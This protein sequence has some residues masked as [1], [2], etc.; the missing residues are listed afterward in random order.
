L[1]QLR[2][3]AGPD[4]VTDAAANTHFQL[5]LR[6][7]SQLSVMLIG[8]AVALAVLQAGQVI[9]APV[10]LAITVGLMFGPVADIMEKRGVPS[11]LSAAVI[12][13]L[14]LAIIIAGGALFAAP[15]AEWVARIPV[16]WER[17]RAELA[18]LR[19]PLAAFGALQEQ[20][21]DLTGGD[22]AMAVTVE[23][24][25]A[26]TELA[27]L[28]PAILAQVLIFLASLYFFMATRESIRIS[29]LSLCVSR[30]MRW[31]T[32][33][34]FRDVE[35]KVSKYLLTI[36]T[37]NIG[38]GVVVTA[39]MWAIG[40]P[41]PLLWGALAAV[42]NYIPFV[43]QAVMALI[44]F[45][46]GL[47]TQTGISGAMLP[48]VLYW[49]VNFTEG[50]FV[51]PNLLG[52]T[53]T[54]NPFLIFLSLTF[55]IWSWGPIGGL[56]AVPSLLILYSLA[57]HILPVGPLAHRQDRRPLRRGSQQPPATGSEPPVGA[58]P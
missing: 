29:T 57:T 34:V 22:G 7:A 39:I 58:V 12:V 40:L 9:L 5:L 55:W 32:A 31:R 17:F 1:R 18:N 52:R 48:V 14:L 27:L 21:K 41:S 28:A 49:A 42:L 11:T 36:S 19:E 8:L 20:V 33:H 26:V 6:N 23:D 24:G 38:V 25:G 47:A 13:L 53:M 10:F 3:L 56:I 50:N 43:G 54:M 35:F 2:S 45:M 15:L 44:L 16:I 4:G 46:V 51:T 37:V 30:R